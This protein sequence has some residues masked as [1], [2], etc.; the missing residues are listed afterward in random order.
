MNG[1][2][3]RSSPTASTARLP[4][5]VGQ[6]LDVFERVAI[7]PVRPTQPLG[8]KPQPLGALLVAQRRLLRGRDRAQGRMLTVASG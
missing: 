5:G 1:A 2:S 8:E 3:L 4:L 7:Q 6:L